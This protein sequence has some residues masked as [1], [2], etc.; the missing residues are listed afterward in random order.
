MD[1]PSVISNRVRMSSP[2]INTNVPFSHTLSAYRPFPFGCLSAGKALLLMPSSLPSRQR[3][4]PL[5]FLAFTPSRMSIRGCPSSVAAM[6]IR[7]CR[8]GFSVLPISTHSSPASGFTPPN[9]LTGTSTPPAITEATSTQY[10]FSFLPPVT[11]QRIRSWA[12]KP[13]SCSNTMR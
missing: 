3:R 9:S 5:K 4:Q 6:D 13:D 1:F 2:V 11:A 7:F 12:T 10:A 8:S